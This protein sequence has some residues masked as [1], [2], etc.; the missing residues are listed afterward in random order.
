MHSEL[1]LLTLALY[2]A[3][4]QQAQMVH[5]FKDVKFELQCHVSGMRIAASKL[6]NQEH[7]N[8][9]TWAAAY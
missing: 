4:K 5:G 9:S 2:F 8:S 7:G 1:I 3:E 6:T